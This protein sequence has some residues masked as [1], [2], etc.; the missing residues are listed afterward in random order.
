MKKLNSPYIVQ[1]FRYDEENNEYLM[2]YMDY[3]LDKYITPN[4]T[5]IT[6]AQRK[7]LANQ[8]IKAFSYIHSK[9]LL[10]R[11][12]NPKNVLIKEYEDTVIVKISD[13]GLVKVPESGLTTANTDFKGYFNDPSLLVDGFITYNITHETYAITRLLYYVL[14]G[15][16]NVDNIQNPHIKAFI[17]KGLNS[18][19]TQ[20]FQN[21]DE[22]T[23]F[24]RE[25][26]F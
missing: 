14:T 17:S 4:N 23:Q 12:I 2:E 7:S 16:T 26:K 10:H 9:G 25:L 13:F 6:T 21:I 3:S 15:R 8:I 19:K 18:D 20:R 11:D 5:K 22:L 24:F 1:V